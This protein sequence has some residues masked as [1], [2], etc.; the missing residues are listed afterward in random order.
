MKTCP[1]CKAEIQDNANF[2]LYCMTSLDQK[3]TVIPKN[4]ASRRWACLVAVLLALLIALS[5]IAVAS[6]EGFSG[7]SVSSEK[8][9]FS[10]LAP[11]SAPSSAS[12]S[13]S[14]QSGKPESS[15][16]LVT[17]SKGSSAQSTG[18]GSSAEDKT[19]SQ[20]ENVS[21][22]TPSSEQT[23]KPT[24]PSDDPAPEEENTP[25]SSDSDTSSGSPSTPPATPPAT[26]PT[27]T[28]E[29]RPA[30]IGDDYNDYAVIP[31]DA[32]VITKVTS[33]AE[34]GVYDVPQT[35]DGKTVIAI[36]EN[37]FGE[38][39]IKDT[40]KT[41]IIPESVK[42][43]WA[44]GFFYC[45]NLKSLYIK[46]EALFIGGSP[47]APTSRRNETITIYCSATCHN[48]NHT[49]WKYIAEYNNAL[50]VEWNG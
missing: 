32:I 15:P 36:M 48:R 27:V 11:S 19:P 31:T 45:H 9:S 14:T 28:Y 49:K 18:D 35:I 26:Q 1:K 34:D 39:E 37:A 44:Y 20:G 21:E 43:I 46:G 25:P 7:N 17:P 10:V 40:V 12:A 38:P 50:Y 30:T 4:P 2:C 16:E 3:E 41:V 22:N 8:G 23:V 29:Y 5:C 6:F 24:P 47:F 13:S 42:T 33:A